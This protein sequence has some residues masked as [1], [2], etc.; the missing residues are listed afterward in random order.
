[1]ANR[2][3]GDPGDGPSAPPPLRR[4]A[5]SAHPSAAEQARTI[6]AATN[7]GTLATLTAE[8][9]PWA[10]FVA[11]GLLG[12]SPVLC[13]S[14]LAEHGRN[15]TADSRASLSILADSNESDPLARSRITLAGAV[16][17][18]SAAERNTVAEAYL[19]AVPAGRIYLDFSDFTLWVL[20]VQ[21]VRWVGGY[22]R[23]DSVTGEQYNAAAPD[24]VARAAA[25]AIEHLNADHADAM[26]AV[27]RAFGGY[28][29]TDHAVCT[30]IDRYGLDLRVHTPRGVAYAR[31]GFPVQLH[32]ADQLRSA[33][34]E[35]ARAASVQ[36]GGSR[37]T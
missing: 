34:A 9:D 11:Y 1:V 22:G 35:L 4:P 18:P 14:H 2:D 7:A 5:Q 6:A 8:G 30:G 23:M 17:Q 12:G 32:S 13:V 3:H 37:T 21:R 36:D 15:L 26:T 19:K 31:A 24:P 28:P 25:R 29:D 20:R 27:A 10:S 33:C 16:H